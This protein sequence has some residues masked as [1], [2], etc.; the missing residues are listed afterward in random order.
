MQSDLNRGS[1]EE[2]MRD[3]IE[4]T[5]SV[6]KNDKH[7]VSIDYTIHLAATLCSLL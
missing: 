4:W 3:V 1:V 2:K 6:W 7:K 5:E